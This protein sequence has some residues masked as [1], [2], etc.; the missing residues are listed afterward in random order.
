MI[1]ITVVKNGAG[2]TA[3]LTGGN[4]GD[5]YEGPV[6]LFDLGGEVRAGQVIARVHD[7]ERTGRPATDYRAGI[8]GVLAGRHFPGLV[9]PGDS[10]A[11]VAIPV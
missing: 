2:P 6:A 3:L 7:V 9:Q 5:K 8:D 4:H 1:S 10:L 11:V